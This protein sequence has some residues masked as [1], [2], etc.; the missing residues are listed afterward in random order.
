[1][2]WGLDKTVNPYNFG[3]NIN[4]T[5]SNLGTVSS[6]GVWTISNAFFPDTRKTLTANTTFYF[7]T[8]G[9]D[10]NTCLGNTAGTAC[11]TPQ[12]AINK[13][14]SYDLNGY[15][16]TIQG[17]AGT[18]GPVVLNGPFVGATKA[19]SAQNVIL[20][21]DCTSSATWSN[22]VLSATNQSSI[23]MTNGAVATF[24]CI[25]LTTTG[26]TG[27]GFSV[28]S[29][30][31]LNYNNIDFGVVAGSHKDTFDGGISNL[32]GSATYKITGNPAVDHEH[33]NEGGIVNTIN[34]QVTCA[35]SFTTIGGDFA[36]VAGSLYAPGHTY[37]GCGGV[38]NSGAGKRYFVHNWGQILIN[39]SANPTYFPGS[40]AGTTNYGGF[41]DYTFAPTN[42]WQVYCGSTT[43]INCPLVV[44]STNS[45]LT[46]ANSGATNYFN[47]VNT[48]STANSAAQ[49]VMTTGAANHQIYWNLVENGAGAATSTIGSSA[50][51]NSLE[52]KPSAAGSYI[53]ISPANTFA[54]QFAADGNFYPA[55]ATKNIASAVTPLQQVFVKTVTLSTQTIATLPVCNPANLGSIATVS[56]GTTYGVGTYGS[57]V[58][59]A[60]IVTRKVLCTNTAGATTYAWAYD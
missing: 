56:D 40:N 3:A 19:S 15:T 60:G 1:M 49:Y 51:V 4:G 30:A 9:S 33:I 10:S 53:A 45:L 37:T 7:R 36:G 32:I 18:Y 29:N 28:S 5:W 34:A 50:N 38:V 26:A 54:W 41:Y 22:V 2:Q 55:G 16:A 59:G 27:S 35:A 31:I 24:Q 21:G 20:Q 57:A 46:S 17:A 25:K 39:A 43:A 58:G 48:A 8:S 23:S 44:Y 52:I 12:G 13:V 6:T 47:V 14:Y 42:G 11:A